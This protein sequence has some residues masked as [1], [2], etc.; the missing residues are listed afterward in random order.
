MHFYDPYYFVK[1]IN[2]SSALCKVQGAYKHKFTGYLTTL[3]IRDLTG[4][5]QKEEEKER[6]SGVIMDGTSADMQVFSSLLPY[7]LIF[8]E[9]LYSYSY[10]EIL[11]F[12][13][14]L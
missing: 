10:K 5:N 8:T 7:C 1:I 4:T 14:V 3:N 6:R 2:I 13:E 11:E 12:L 9:R